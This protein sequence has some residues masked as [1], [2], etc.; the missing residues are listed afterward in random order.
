M[1]ADIEQSDVEERSPLVLDKNSCPERLA[2][3]PIRLWARAIS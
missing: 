3:V 2:A 1:E